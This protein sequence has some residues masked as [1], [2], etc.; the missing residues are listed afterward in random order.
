M[1]ICTHVHVYPCTCICVH[2]HVYVSTLS[3]HTCKVFTLER[4]LA[5]FE[6]STFE[7][8]PLIVTINQAQVMQ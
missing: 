7:N 2:V 4:L 3:N 5:K 6:T 8:H 1:Y